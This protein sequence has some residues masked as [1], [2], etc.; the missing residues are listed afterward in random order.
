MKDLSYTLFGLS[1]FVHCWVGPKYLVGDLKKSYLDS[2]KWT[3]AMTDEG[4]QCLECNVPGY[5]PTVKQLTPRLPGSFTHLA[6]T[7]I[8]RNHNVASTS[9]KRYD[10]LST[11]I[12]R[13]F[14][15]VRVWFYG[16]TL[17]WYYHAVSTYMSVNLITV[18]LHSRFGFRD[19]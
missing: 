16:H 2:M 11:L 7:Y 10:I 8:S 17:H 14:V 12:W 9:K 5:F 3:L 4:K 6:N 15:N 1:V 18:G 13:C 19:S